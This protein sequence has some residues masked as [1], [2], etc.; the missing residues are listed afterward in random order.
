MLFHVPGVETSSKRLTLVHSGRTHTE[1][2]NKHEHNTVFFFF[3]FENIYFI[4]NQTFFF[5]S[6]IEL[7]CFRLHL[8]VK[9][10]VFLLADLSCDLLL[11]AWQQDETN[12]KQPVCLIYL[13][14][15]D[16]MHILINIYKTGS[17]VSGTCYTQNKFTSIKNM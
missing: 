10:C 11:T 1:M 4:C 15:P 13:Y 5:T 6:T 9:C 14:D 16:C 17:S 8:L 12:S 7:P 3:F 2:S